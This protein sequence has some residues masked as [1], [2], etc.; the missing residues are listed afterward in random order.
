MYAC[1]DEFNKVIR[2]KHR[3]IRAAIETAEKRDRTL[4]KQ[5]Y[6]GIH[7]VEA[8]SETGDIRDMT[9]AEKAEYESVKYTER[10]ERV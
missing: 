8:L 10:G 7:T 9:E 6:E 5:G 3:T 2:S 4:N 1:Y